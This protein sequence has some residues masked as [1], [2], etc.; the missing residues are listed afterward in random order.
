MSDNQ[1]PAGHS[2][3]LFAG[4]PLP[5]PAPEGTAPRHPVDVFLLL[6]DADRVLLGLRSGTGYADG[7]WALPS[8]KLE[9]GEDAISAVIR[10]T[11]E[12]TGLQ[13]PANELRLAAVVHHRPVA[14]IARVGLV[15]AVL[16]DV[17]RH[18]EPVN[19]EPHKCAKIAW[20]RSGQLPTNTYPYSA[21]AVH[22]VRDNEPLVLS[23][24][25]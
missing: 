11:R 18:G 22:A 24:W 9:C 4:P 20:F 15:F 12:E 25:S 2:A 10:E 3:N 13:L 21:A 19:A 8:G 1:H 6:T 17:R 14:G 23:G 16:F 7:Q 5:A